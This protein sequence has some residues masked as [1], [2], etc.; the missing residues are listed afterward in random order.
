MQNIFLIFNSSFIV[1]FNFFLVYSVH[2]L[3][4]G[5]P[6]PRYALCLLGRVVVFP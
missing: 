4:S 3:E 1:I 5:V 6:L 2:T